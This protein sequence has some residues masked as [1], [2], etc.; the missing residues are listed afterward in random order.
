VW[1][2]EVSISIILPNLIKYNT[3]VRMGSK[4]DHIS[5]KIRKRIL[6]KLLPNGFYFSQ[7]GYCP[8]CDR[9]VTF[10]S[11]NSW[12]R[13]FFICTN[14]WSLPRERALI[15]TIE[16]YYPDWRNLDIHES[17]PGN[18]GASIKLKDNCKNYK[19]SQYYPGEPCGIFVN[20]N[21]N[22]NL[23]QQTFN[24]DSFDIVVSQDVMEHVYNP[25]KAFAEIARTLRKGG[26]HIFTVP[27]INKHGKTE[28]CATKGDNG[29][30]VF[31]K[32]PEYHTNPVDPTGS[33]VTMHYGFDI[34]D[35][36]QE[37]SGL[38]TTVEYI[39]NLK[40]GISAEYNEILVSQKK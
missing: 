5:Q 28:V 26:A 17:S 24:D 37:E 4:S 31:L 32:D 38:E 23:E 8:C 35:F 9:E 15:L 34:V 30:P 33:P 10:E 13:D 27:I 14:C 29:D 40:Y 7:K 19:S 6:N 3:D 12:L 16:K 21:R 2:N 1:L 36:I 39:Y 22:E 25:G 18:R 20:D 11:Y